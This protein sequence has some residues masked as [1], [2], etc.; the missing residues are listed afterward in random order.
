MAEAITLLRPMKQYA[1]LVGVL[2]DKMLII[3]TSFGGFIFHSLTQ[4][5]EMMQRQH[6]TKA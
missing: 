3:F 1:A 5:T 2:N 4:L 6:R